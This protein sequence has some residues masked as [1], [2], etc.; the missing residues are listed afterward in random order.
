METGI[1][2]HH[3]ISLSFLKTTFT[4]MLAK[5]LQY[6]NCKQFETNS[7]LQDVEELPKKIVIQ[8]GKI[9]CEHVKQTHSSQKESD[10]RKS[11][12]FHHKKIEKNDFET[13]SFGK[14]GIN[15]SN[16]PEIIK[17]CI[18]QRKY[19]FNLSRKVRTE[20]FPKYTPH[21]ASLTNF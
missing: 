7:F 16:N 14:E 19:V 3:A 6:R 12:T 20:Y 4:K 17:L 15:T 18:K 8:N 11:Q 9:F 10:S 21:G 13:I 5:K 2:D 1:S